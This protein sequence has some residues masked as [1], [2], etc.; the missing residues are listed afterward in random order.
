[1]TLQLA[2]RPLS[3]LALTA[4]VAWSSAARATER[5][6]MLA[7]LPN[8]GPADA[9]YSSDETA[10]RPSA[11]AAFTATASSIGDSLVG[12]VRNTVSGTAAVAGNMSQ[13]VSNTVKSTV[14][15][16]ANVAGAVSHAVTNTVKNTV[17]GSVNVAG[18]IGNVVADTFTSTVTGTVNVAGTVTHAVADTV[19]SATRSLVSA[20]KKMLNY[21]ESLIGTPYKWGGTSI[22]NGLDCSGFVQE[23]VK[24]ATGKLLPRTAREMSEAGHKVARDD[25]KPGDL[26]FFNTRRRPYSHVGIYLGNGEFVHGASGVKSGKQVRVDKLDSNYYRKRYNGARRITLPAGAYREDMLN[27]SLS[28]SGDAALL[29]R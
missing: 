13:A 29:S 26:V 2:L 17:V 8:A 9:P 16:T 23:V 24:T 15:G 12:T 18:T 21:A 7:P 22:V 4:A 10:K 25:L 11:G 27:L 3:I 28:A 1:M 19:G 5:P 6:D 20:P 14:V